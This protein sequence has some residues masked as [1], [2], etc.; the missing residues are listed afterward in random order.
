M[1]DIHFGYPL[2]LIMDH[3]IAGGCGILHGHYPTQ[4]SEIDHMNAVVG[5]SYDDTGLVSFIIDDPYGDYRQLYSI[6]VGND[7]TMPLCDIVKYI[8]NVK[9]VHNKDIILIRRKD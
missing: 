2:A 8:K 1:V 5:L 6:H 4:K 9:D 7:I 3:I